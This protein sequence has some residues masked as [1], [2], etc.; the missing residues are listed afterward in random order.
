MTGAAQEEKKMK[1]FIRVLGA[2]LVMHLAALPELALP[3][4][5]TPAVAAPI[6]NPFD[7]EK[8]NTPAKLAAR[9][10]ASLEKDPSGHEYIN[11]E[12]CAKNG[13]CAT[14]LAYLLMFQNDDPKAAETRLKTVADLPDYLASLT[15]TDAPLGKYWMAC[16]K[17]TN[18]NPDNHWQPIAKCI[19]RAFKP[20]EH[21]WM[22]PVTK[23]IVLAEDCT[24]PVEKPEGPE[25]CD[26]IQFYTGADITS[27]RYKT[28]GPTDMAEETVCTPALKRAG[29]TDWEYPWEDNCPSEWCTFADVD[30]RIPEE[31]WRMGSF[32]V[33][34]GLHRLRVP[35]VATVRDSHYDVVFCSEKTTDPGPSSANMPVFQDPDL[36]GLRTQYGLIKGTETYNQ[37]VLAYDAKAIEWNAQAVAWNALHSCGVPVHWYDYHPQ[38]DGRKVAVIYNNQDDL[39]KAKSVDLL[40]RPS[41]LRWEFSRKECP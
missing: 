8:G 34:R 19:A 3:V 17:F 32:T 18:K 24:N 25:L 15:I 30:A 21:A 23:R 9:V 13:S 16:L 35:H 39:K 20:G 7:K 38:P 5:V 26:E 22:D 28:H 37:Q 4:F 2:L 41:I 10:R 29:E 31:G 1:K 40:G 27:V 36:Q 11:P 14:P 12:G 33:K 6:G